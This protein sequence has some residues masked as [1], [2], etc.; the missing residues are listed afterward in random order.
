[1]IGYAVGLALAAVLAKNPVVEAAA[2]GEP[3]T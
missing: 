3:A 1:L 2:A